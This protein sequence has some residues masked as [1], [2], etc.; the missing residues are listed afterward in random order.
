MKVLSKT[1]YVIGLSC[2]KLLW[3]N[4]NA[5]EKVPVFDETTQ[6]LF[7]QGH[8]VGALAKSLYPCGVEVVRDKDAKQRTAAL[9]KQ[10]A[11]IYEA[12]FLY[13]NAYCKTDI[14]VPAGKEWDIIEVKSS[15]SV[16][17]EHVH[18][19]AFQRYCVE[20]AGLKVR[21]TCL[22]HINTAYE[23][24][25]EIDA[26]GLFT[27][28]DITDKVAE[29]LPGIEGNINAML[30]IIAGKMPEPKLGTECMNPKECPVCMVDLPD[31][32]VSELYHLGAKA[33]PLINTGTLLIKDLPVDYE[34]NSKQAIQKKA[35]LSGKPHIEPAHLK[36]WLKQLKYPLHFLDF[37][38]I[39]PAIPLFEVTHPYQNVPF[40]LSLHVVE[41]EGAKPN[42][43]EFLVDG[44]QDPRPGIVD[45][46]KNIHDGTIVAFNAVFEKGVIRD[47]ATAFPADKWLGKLNDRFVDL[48]EPF[49]D[50]SY[51]HPEQ[52]GSCSLKAVL[53]AL[54]GKSYKHLEVSSGDVAARKFLAMTYKNEKVDGTA[55]RKALLIYCKQDTQ[56]MIDVLKVLEKAAI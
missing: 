24:H 13:K 19:V 28:E 20:G 30:A 29:L 44:P 51:Y 55:L 12:S 2:P 27:L 39:N 47:L 36:S 50:F 16:K 46:L 9:V 37:E 54:T 45:A 7:D 35:V 56:A 26:A 38:T 3:L 22:L 10:R 17:P 15:G 23:R 1:N 18:D 8:E 11:T 34:L 43:H 53:P 49:R 4:Y 5:P 25:G 32:N 40:Q 21:K 48:I 31:D 41:K 6:A 14:I 42:H 33:Y 52:H